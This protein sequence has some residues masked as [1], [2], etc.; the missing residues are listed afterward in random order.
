M[1]LLAKSATEG[2]LTL[3]EHTAHVVATVRAMAAQYNIPPE[4]AAH[5][6][7]LHDLGKAHPE[8]QHKLDERNRDPLASLL[9]VAHRH[10]VSSI[11]FLPLFPRDEWEALVDMTVAHHKST[12]DD[13]RDRGLLDLVRVDGLD[14]TF[15]T[16][17]GDWATWAPRVRELLTAYGIAWREIDAQERR[18]AF[19]F[20]VAHCKSRPK[21]WSRL[22]GLLMGADHFASA[23][24]HE[25]EPRL[26]SL[27]HKPDLAFFQR[28]SPLFPLSTRPGDS[29]RPHTLVVA[30]TGAGKTDYLMRR[31]A[32]RTFY[33]LPFQVSIN[34]MYDRFR[35]QLGDGTDIRLQHA[36]SRLKLKRNGEA[37]EQI[38][39][40]HPGAAV[41]VMTPHQMAALAFGTG[42]YESLAL[43]V[44]GQDVILDEIHAYT[45][46]SRA[47]MLALVQ[48]LAELNCRVHI[49]SATFP[50]VLR[51]KLL[52]ALGGADRVHEERL[53][54]AELE[55]FDRHC[56]HKLSGE[57]AADECLAAL[58]ADGKHVLLIS[59]RVARAQERYARLRESPAEASALLLH[60]RFRRT[61]RAALESR[62]GELEQKPGPCV[63]CATQVVEVSLDVS[64]DAMITD[65]A[66]LDA[67][68]QRF[69]RVNRRR[70]PETIGRL[71]DVY[72]VAPPD[73]DR[74]VLPYSAD[75][76]RRSF[77][78]LPDDHA[79]HEVALQKLIDDV[80]PTIECPSIGSHLLL[81]ANGD[82]RLKELR[83]HPR[84]H[85]LECMSYDSAACLRSADADTYL[86][87]DAAT[88]MEL[89][90]PVSWKGFGWRLRDCRQLR[91]GTHPFVVP[92]NWYDMELGLQ[93]TD[94]TAAPIEERML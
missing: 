60:S 62:I 75:T 39:Q 30:P 53:T 76:V 74:D 2:G 61:D 86:T 11:L 43:D 59:N 64:F 38:L 5:G 77:A 12:R 79:L 37:E 48:V 73:E 7:L 69:G 84:S 90:V 34:A 58:V 27:Y 8:F 46:V 81:D 29:S 50:T 20:A 35:E 21:G 55:S 36:A 91:V 94:A 45:D 72:I 26:S 63:V 40:G 18:E 71:K 44:S 25:T 56:V 13:A 3:H 1:S 31:C 19:D 6:A 68:V 78:S 15:E 33:T 89:E 14:E 28:S 22:R 92:D 32:G 51:E 17:D 80:Y 67:L 82:C 87:G 47:F 52:E 16:H 42:G 10:E 65:A 83:H 66:P 93:P 4:L 41:K 85:I 54:D 88:R 9:S 24:I 57:D 49:G 70:T 23:L